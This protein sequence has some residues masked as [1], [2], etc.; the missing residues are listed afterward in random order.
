MIGNYSEVLNSNQ[1]ISQTQLV[2]LSTSGRFFS[3]IGLCVSMIILSE[4]V[5]R[6]G[7]SVKRGLPC[8]VI[9]LGGFAS[10]R[11]RKLE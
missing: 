1:L 8:I 10:V 7:C 3:F 5:V 11:T 4:V 6:S 9:L 2:N